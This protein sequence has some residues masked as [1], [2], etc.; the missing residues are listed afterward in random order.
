[1]VA[2]GGI[3]LRDIVGDG[4]VGFLVSV[5]GWGC[6]VVLF[7]RMSGSVRFVYAKGVHV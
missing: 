4:E 6:C 7:W 1:M 5:R 2:G 3:F